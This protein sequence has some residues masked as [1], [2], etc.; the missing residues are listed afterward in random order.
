MIDRPPLHMRVFRIL[1]VQFIDM[2]FVSD[3]KRAKA[4][5][6]WCCLMICVAGHGWLFPWRKRDA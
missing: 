3:W 6:T 2:D 5:E 1:G 4:G